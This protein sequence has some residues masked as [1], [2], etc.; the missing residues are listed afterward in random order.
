[1]KIDKD[2]LSV[3]KF[4]KDAHLLV[5]ESRPMPG[6]VLHVQ[7]GTPDLIPPQD[8]E[9]CPLSL[10]NRLVGKSLHPKLK[11][12]IRPGYSPD[13]QRPT[14]QGIVDMINVILSSPKELRRFERTELLVYESPRYHSAKQMGRS[15]VRHMMHRYWGNFSIFGLDLCGAVIRQGVFTEK[16]TKV[17][18]LYLTTLTCFL[19][20]EAVLIAPSQIDW[21]HSPA[22]AG[23]MVRLIDRYYRFVSLMADEPNRSF[24]PT[25]DID[26]AWH[27]HQLSPGAYYQYTSGTC[28]KYVDHDDKIGEEQLSTA[29]QHT[30]LA[31]QRKFG[32]VYS[33][34]TCWYCES[35]TPRPLNA[36]Y[37]KLLTSAAQLS[38]PV[39]WPLASAAC[40]ACRSKTEV[41]F[42]S[43][44][45]SF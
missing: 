40:S 19:R 30:S 14:L 35:K 5:Y 33:E 13:H 38:D 37:Q 11:D 43:P 2:L 16:M 12:F 42:C 10:P 45:P 29:F 34:C 27:T 4:M 23:M 9:S 24:V 32:E 28:G 31:Y 22:A 8:R 6:A 26:L 44:I 41:R 25:L 7:T 3:D 15:G 18:F 20:L 39:T 36:C 17:C 21:L 1:M